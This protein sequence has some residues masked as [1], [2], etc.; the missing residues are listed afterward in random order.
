LDQGWGG[1]IK[2]PG[3]SCVMRLLDEAGKGLIFDFFQFSN[4]K[5]MH[6]CMGL[7]IG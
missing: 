3:I 4:K 7:N 1:Y 2:L 5:P 6:F